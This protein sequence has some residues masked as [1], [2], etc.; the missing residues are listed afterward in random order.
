MSEGD[1]IAEFNE[2]LEVMPDDAVLRLCGR[3]ILDE[4]TGC[5]GRAH[6]RNY[7]CLGNY[8]QGR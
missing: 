7:I 2:D 1:R 5:A 3:R 8:C 6:G 4:G